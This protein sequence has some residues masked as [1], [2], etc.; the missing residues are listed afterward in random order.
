MWGPSYRPRYKEQG[1]KIMQY[2]MGDE[3][4]T[5]NV[6][7]ND[8]ESSIK[9][10]KRM[11]EAEEYIH[12]L[13]CSLKLRVNEKHSYFEKNFNK[14]GSEISPFIRKILK[15][16]LQVISRH[17]SYEIIS[18]EEYKYFTAYIWALFIKGE[19]QGLKKILI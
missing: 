16:N 10:W 13:Q 11:G 2:G 6:V 18:T 3:A 4:M 19:K 14:F 9:L 12:G 15:S 17:V 1:H 7:L 8:L 5:F